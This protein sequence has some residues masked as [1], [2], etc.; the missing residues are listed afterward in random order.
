MPIK[1]ANTDLVD[2]HV[3]SIFSPDSQT[4]LIEYIIQAQNLGLKG[5]CFTEHGDYCPTEMYYD[6]FS[7]E[8]YSLSHKEAENFLIERE[9]DL[10]LLKGI[11]FSEPHLYIEKF[12]EIKKMNFD[13]IMAAVHWIQGG[14]VGDAEII[15]N[16]SEREIFSYYY[17]ELAKT[18]TLG[19]FD[20]LAHFDFP[21]RYLG[22]K[23]ASDF[24]D[25]EAD[26]LEI[27][28]SKNIVLE[29]NTS[30]IRQTGLQVMPSQRILQ[31]YY[32]LGGR[33]VVLA[34]DA[35]RV[36]ELG[37]DIDLAYEIAREI[38]LSICYCKNHNFI[39]LK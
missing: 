29:I 39:P 31:K 24:P 38:G 14:F 23:F 25:K 18:A 10:I 9:I 16:Y 5:I 15:D 21:R 7:Y 32:S 8:Q 6:Y 20:V 4:T 1:R 26:V 19:G 33:K 17:D 35:H 27:L 30:I 12:N 36:N 3:H 37:Q 13:M 34:S 11:E 28:I 2:M 22:P